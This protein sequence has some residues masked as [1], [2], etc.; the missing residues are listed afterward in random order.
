MK[1][2]DK[3]ARKTE[4]WC[5]DYLIKGR[6]GP[7]LDT[8]EPTTQKVDVYDFG[9]SGSVQPKSDPTKKGHTVFFTNLQ[10]NTV[11]AYDRAVG[12]RIHFN[13]RAGEGVRI[14]EDE[15]G[16]LGPYSEDLNP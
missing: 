9:S 13:A 11:L 15:S 7:D 12:G 14:Y 4:F 5:G 16:N 2:R 10:G 6:L 1:K 3:N 8:G